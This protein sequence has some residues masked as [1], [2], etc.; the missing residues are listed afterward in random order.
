MPSRLYIA[1]AAVLSL[2]TLHVG[3][4]SGDRSRRSEATLVAPSAKPIRSGSRDRHA[5]GD[6]REDYDNKY[7]TTVK[8]L[9]ANGTCSG[10]L[11]AP[12]L[13]L[14]AAHCFCRIT[15]KP[16]DRSSCQKETTVVRVF[17]FYDEGEKKYKRDLDSTK[18]RVIVHDD[19]AS[20]HTPGTFY[21]E[22]DK[23]IPDLAV[24]RLDRALVD[25]SPPGPPE[26]DEDLR[27]AKKLQVDVKLGSA[28]VSLDQEVVVVGYGATEARGKDVG[29]RRFGGNVVAN[30]RLIKKGDNKKRE[31]RLIFPGAKAFE[32][33]SGGPCLLE[34]E[35][36]RWLVG[37]IGGYGEGEKGG[38]E[39]WFTST[40]GYRDWIE[41]QIAEAARPATD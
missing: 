29:T 24:V 19:Y 37:I 12:R 3:C 2:A 8:V 17:Y 33:D 13:V 32:G 34:D 27:S 35:N 16:L 31:I 15:E 4:A 9:S 14:T 40:F 28:D 11:I 6:G 10:I 5:I 25:G 41:A 39:S 22:D 23:K 21:I 36:S 38:T 18:G 20:Q 1:F 30:L 26:G 7:Q